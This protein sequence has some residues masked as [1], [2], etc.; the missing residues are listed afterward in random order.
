[1]SLSNRTIGLLAAP[2]EG[3]NGPSHS[4]IDLIWTT[5]DAADYIGDGN[6][7]DRVLFGLR[8]LRDG[9]P[10][11]EFAPELPPD[12]KKLQ[13]VAEDLANRLLQYEDVDRERLDE[14]L[15]SD[16]M[17]LDE[18]GRLRSV[19]PKDA[20]ADRLGV[21]VGELFGKRDEFKVASRHFEQASRAFDRGDYEAANAQYRSAL[22]ATFDTLAHALGCPAGKKGGAARKWLTE[23]GHLED[24][25]A[26]LLKAFAGFAGRAGSHAGLS[27]AADS[28][29]R[30]HFAT[31]LIAF[32][33]S[34]LG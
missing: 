33:V 26:D 18:R 6:K 21:Y 4:T 20:P 1:M 10:E 17:M 16:G 19:R 27:G 25:E 24:D 29:L 28:Q 22:D 30:R 12:D 3:G 13:A 9:R 15:A 34:K 14:A 11:R 23:N 2:F 7:L 31:A 32:G 8:Y 5:A